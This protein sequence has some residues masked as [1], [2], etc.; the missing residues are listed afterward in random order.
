[1]RIT[2]SAAQAIVQVMKSKGLNPENTF[3]EIGVFE[4][5]LGMGFT[6]DALGKR[7][8]SGDL[9]IVISSEVDASGVVIDFGETNG[10]KGLI[11]LGEQ[12]NVN[13]SN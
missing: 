11:F 4:G 1:M 7:V 12:Q 5:N 8:K 13:N 3:L 9:T 10:K 6:R 2:D